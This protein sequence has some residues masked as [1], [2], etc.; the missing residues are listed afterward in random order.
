MRWENEWRIKYRLQF[1]SDDVAF[2][3]V[4]DDAYESIIRWTI[5]EDMMYIVLP[6]SI[7]RDPLAYLRLLPKLEHH[8]WHQI[9]LFQG[10]KMDFDEFKPYTA[11]DRR[12]MNERAGTILNCFV[13]TELQQVYEERFI[14]RHLAFVNQ[15]NEIALGSDLM[16]RLDKVERNAKEP[17]HSSVDLAKAAYEKLFNIQKDRITA[18][19][20]PDNGS[21][22]DCD[23]DESRI[24]D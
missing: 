11:E 10:L 2:L 5:D 13:R 14:K 4:P 20:F 6:T 3:F 21:G 16:G 1:T 15:L 17:W 22:G 24:G 12:L 8:G 18:N 19:W 23:H 9:E 7:I